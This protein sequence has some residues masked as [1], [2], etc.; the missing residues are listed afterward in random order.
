MSAI[1]TIERIID[2]KLV[3]E[4]LKF[5][6]VDDRKRPFTINNS[7][8][9]VSNTSDFVN[10][11][12]LVN[13]GDLTKYAGIGISVQASEVCAVDIDKCVTAPFDVSSIN[14]FAL[15]II[16]IFKDFAYIEF[17]FSGT[18]IRILFKQQSIDNY[19]NKYKIKNSYSHL[20]YY[21]PN[22]SNRYVTVTGKYLFNNSLTSNTDYSNVII[23][24]LEKY[25][26]KQR[27]KVQQ[28]IEPSTD[29]RSIDELM[30]LVKYHYFNSYNF[31]D[32]WFT[33]APGS[34]KDE[35]ER[36]YR[37]IK[38]I[39]KHITQDKLKVKEV[40]EQSE[41]FKTKD[42]KHVFKWTRNDHRYFNFVFDNIRRELGGE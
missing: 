35:S 3:Y 1:E 18:G 25:M 15:E 21:Q 31:Q 7:M 22:H 30:K 33:H 20:E 11:E 14:D 39:Y 23:E 9:S 40:F 34:G 28:R 24:F 5:C 32:L 2:T 10:F 19:S 17:S 26:K 4:D 6:L 16:D 12:T 27:S 36:D 8:A 37:L 38:Y 29:N 41:F 42:K 13:Y